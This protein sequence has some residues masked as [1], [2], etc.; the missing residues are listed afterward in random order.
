MDQAFSKEGSE[1]IPRITQ[2]Q[3]PSRSKTP[4]VHQQQTPLRTQ[5]S[6]TEERNKPPTPWYS[7]PKLPKKSTHQFHWSPHQSPTKSTSLQSKN[8]EEEKFTCSNH[9]DDYKEKKSLESDKFCRW[10]ME[11][12]RVW[13][14]L[15]WNI[16]KFVGKSNPQA[17]GCRLCS[18]YYLCTTAIS[19]ILGHSHLFQL[20]ILSSFLTSRS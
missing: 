10:N 6:P 18:S 15:W 8:N 16:D 4:S 5:H 12:A 7:P 3:E 14:L 1:I 17:P 19:W 9:S 2:E 11:R 13:N 20:E